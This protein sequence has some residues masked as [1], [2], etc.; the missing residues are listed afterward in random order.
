MTAV[1]EEF[2]NFN[3]AD[4][5]LSIHVTY[6][7]GEQIVLKNDEFTNP[8]YLGFGNSPLDEISKKDLYNTYDRVLIMCMK[9]S[10]DTNNETTSVDVM[11]IFDHVLTNDVV[12]KMKNNFVFVVGN[13]NLLKQ[14]THHKMALII[15]RKYLEPFNNSQI[16]L[17]NTEI[18]IPMYELKGD[19]AETYASLYDDSTNIHDL[20]KILTFANSY[21]KD[22]KQPINQQLHDKISSMGKLCFWSYSHNCAINATDIFMKRKFNIKYDSTVNNSTNETNNNGELFDKLS[23]M[24]NNDDIPADKTD[25]L[26]SIYR[27]KEYTDVASTLRNMKNRKFYATIDDGT[28]DTTK[29]QITNL[30]NFL[31][32]KKEIFNMF[33]SLLMSKDFCHMVLNNQIVLE[34]MKPFFDRYLSLYRYAFGYAWL[35]FYMEECWFQTK[36]TNKSRFVFDINTANKLP[37]FPT[38]TEDLHLNPYISMLVSSKIIDSVNNYLSIPSIADYKNYGIGTLADFRLKFNVFTT[39]RTDKNIF[40]GIDWA[41]FSVS[42]STITACVPKRSPLMDVILDHAN[43]EAEQLMAFF[44]NYYVNSD[45]DLMCNDISVFG[46]MDKVSSLVTLIKTNLENL[47]D[48]D[49]AATIRLEPIKTLAMVVH[50]KY[51]EL[52][53]THIQDYVGRQWTTEEIIKNLNTNEMKEYFYELYTKEK[54]KTNRQNR[55]EHV[56]ENVNPLYSDF[57]KVSSIDEMKVILVDYDISQDDNVENDSQSCTYLNDVLVDTAKVKPYENI[58]IMKM[59]ESIRFKIKSEQLLHSIEVFRVKASSEFFSTVGRFHLPCV[60][61]HYDGTN[62]YLTAS[63][64][65]ALMTGVNIDYKY[66]A[67]VRDPTEIITKYAT[68]GYTTPVNDREK[69]HIVDYCS[70]TNKFGGMFN[71]DR[72]NKDSIKKFFGAKTLNDECFKPRKHLSGYPDDAYRKVD[73]KYIIT[74]QD[75]QNWYS[76]H[77]PGLKDCGVNFLNFKSINNDGSIEPFK[78]WVFDTVQDTLN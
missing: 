70:S 9:N 38:C 51:I 73:A 47:K 35:A 33:N 14:N 28:L 27:Q 69:Q 60:R 24:K 52:N 43:T 16:H 61:S 13:K 23:N 29:E 65:T 20:E 75:L 22:Y 18:V 64:V 30:F 36:T 77:C 67:G 4:D 78:S 40:D 68:R 37:Y 2:G 63:C 12:D 72:K 8:F 32:N 71:V 1:L 5:D 50:I 44:N 34:K 41:N 49:A 42:G 3:L 66:F 6:V 53:L 19:N 74:V 58:M 46:F 62:V 7:N 59:S 26:S 25:Y 10:Y 45:I 55:K 15:D 57:Y 56:G 76:E 39:G 48:K 11:H 54:F 31:T 21:N 17:H